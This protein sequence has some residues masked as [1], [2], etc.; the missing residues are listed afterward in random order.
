MKYSESTGLRTARRATAGD[1]KAKMSKVAG[2]TMKSKELEYVGFGLRV[3]A[4]IID[5][6]LY[7]LI[8]GLI[9]WIWYGDSYFKYAYQGFWH[10]PMEIFVG[11]IFPAVSTIL[12]WRFKQTTL[13]KMVISSK[14]V[15]AKT[16]GRLT[17]G[18]SVG[19]CLAYVLAVV[20]FG[21]GIVWV[22]FDSRKRGWHD[23]LAGTVVVR[24]KK[25]ATEPVVFSG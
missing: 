13:G 1:S 4:A 15:D 5:A 12:F 7:L 18:Q 21:M 6:V 8:A 24:N 25:I 9:F 17:V 3:W 22:A 16:G 23:R 2:S 10:G 11:C 19:R 20:P 14:I